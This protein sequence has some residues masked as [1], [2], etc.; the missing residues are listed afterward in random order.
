MGEDSIGGHTHGSSIFFS[1]MIPRYTAFF[2]RASATLASSSSFTFIMPRLSISLFRSAILSW[3]FLS[4]SEM[5][6]GGMEVFWK[7]GRDRVSDGLVDK[8]Y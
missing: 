3:I 6:I 5:M 8:A 1:L 4:N 2:F 7:G